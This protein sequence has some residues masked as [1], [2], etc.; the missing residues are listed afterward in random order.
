MMFLN[1]ARLSQ[2]QNQNTDAIY[3]VMIALRCFT[4]SLWTAVI[5]CTCYILL[6]SSSES[7]FY[8]VWSCCAMSFFQAFQD[9]LYD[10]FVFDFHCESLNFTPVFL[11]DALYCICLFCLIVLVKVLSFCSERESERESYL[12]AFFFVVVFMMYA[13]ML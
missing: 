10:V 8:Y 13:F 3:L 6:M 12:I 2:N 7:T 11:I 4:F 5:T 1:L 9:E